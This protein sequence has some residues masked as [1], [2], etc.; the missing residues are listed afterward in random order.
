MAIMLQGRLHESTPS[1]KLP[2]SPERSQLSHED[3]LQLK[4][5]VIAV[6]KGTEKFMESVSVGLDVRTPEAYGAIYRSVQYLTD[7][8][9]IFQKLSVQHPDSPELRD[10]S[11][12][13]VRMHDMAIDMEKIKRPGSSSKV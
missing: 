9:D 7:A 13:A 6:F 11:L 10:A 8:K 4:A 5:A 1:P 12:E 3:S 2:I